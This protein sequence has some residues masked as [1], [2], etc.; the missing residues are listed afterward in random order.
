MGLNV[1]QMSY[2]NKALKRDGSQFFNLKKNCEIL[3]KLGPT[4][5]TWP[6]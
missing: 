1:C 2:V 4:E 6:N 3:V 5:L